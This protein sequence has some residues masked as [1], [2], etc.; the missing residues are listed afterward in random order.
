MDR[1]H[2]FVTSHVRLASFVAL[3]LAAAFNAGVA[4]AQ[5]PVPSTYWTNVRD[6]GAIGDGIHDDGP[7]IIAAIVAADSGNKRVVYFPPTSK[8]YYVNGLQLP[9]L[10][11]FLKLFLDAPIFTSST[12][13]VSSW[14]SIYGDISAEPA[15]FEP[16]SG[17]WIHSTSQNSSAPIIE[18]D[19]NHVTLAGLQID[20]SPG[21]PIDGIRFGGSACCITLT[22]VT[23]QMWATNS[24]G[25]GVH[26]QGGFGFVMQGG[27]YSSPGPN[28]STV[29]LDVDENFCNDS[30]IVNMRDLV[31]AGHGMTLNFPCGGA[32]PF[33][34]DNILFE[35]C[36]DSFLTINAGM[37]VNVLALDLKGIQM[38][39]CHGPPYPP[40]ITN[41][42][43]LVA[44]VKI[45]SSWTGGVGSAFVS[46]ETI[47]DLEIWCPWNFP[48]GQSSEYVLHL[49]TAIISTMPIITPST[50]LPLP[51]EPGQ[52]PSSHSRRF[53][54]P[55]QEAPR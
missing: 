20:E 14:Y 6:Y 24:A 18:V 12:I 39:D 4:I 36:A 16:D 23:V 54:L 21:G 46:G 22:N 50:T 51:I 1:V 44:G 2:Y 26:T 35:S 34:F 38:S 8:H 15:Q 9:P 55:L 28:T 5:T 3:A 42:G 7:A 43:K 32:G 40:M 47:H 25:C 11:T 10:H 48:V 30:G 31:I 29:C 49:P 45:S 33:T 13:V 37:F 27:F 41:H 17:A 53:S 19:G 52:G